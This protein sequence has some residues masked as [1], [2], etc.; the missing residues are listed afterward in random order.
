MVDRKVRA[1]L[2][3]RKGSYVLESDAKRKKWRIHGPFQTGDDVFHVQSDPR[4]PGTIYAA[5]NNGW[6]GPMLMRSRNWGG[7]WTEISTPQTP[8]RSKRSAPVE[9]PSPQYPIKNI[10]HIAPGR[11]SEPRT[12]F[13]GVDPASL[14]R[15]DDEGDSWSPLPGLNDHPTRSKWNPGAGGMCLHTILFDPSRP[16]RMHVGISAAGTFRSDDDGE[17]WT[18]TN[19]G[20]IAGFQPDRHPEVGQCV[21]KVALD[22][23]NPSTMY[24][25]DHCGIYVSHNA[26]DSWT[27]VGRTLEDDFGMGV[28]TAPQLPGEAFFVPLDSMPR[29]IADGHFQV[30]RW[31]EKTRAWSTLVDKRKWP[32]GFGMHRE[33]IATD[34]MNPAGVYVGTTTGQLFWS[35]DGG[36]RWDL[37]PYQF[38]GIHS[39]E[40]ASPG[41]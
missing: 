16:K 31:S 25:Q 21:H 18:P 9:A 8:R 32:G 27:R 23:A 24:R 15:S 10:W 1:L 40:V 39:V 35:A 13:L 11:P 2:G 36:K 5:V 28:A 12:V 22:S 7:K 20:V 33:G 26:A 19:R 3:T 4:H 29:L 17:H 37:V 14:W 41:T 6:W 38:P 30:S 34:A